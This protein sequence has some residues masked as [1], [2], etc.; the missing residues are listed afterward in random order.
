MWISRRWRRRWRRWASRVS[1]RSSKS[2]FL[3]RLGI[4]KRAETLKAKAQAEGA[5]GTE[6]DAALARLIG[7]GRGGMG[8]LFKAAAYAHPSVGVPPGF[9][10]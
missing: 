6:V 4:E 2:E 10:S 9:E 1:V 5:R 3:R 8:T 7:R